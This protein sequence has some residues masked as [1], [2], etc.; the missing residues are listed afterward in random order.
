MTTETLREAVQS[1]CN[2]DPRLGVLVDRWGYPPLWDR[3]EG[4]MTLLFII[5]E[6]QVSLASARATY[7]RLEE[8]IPAPT[9]AGFL[10]LTDETLRTAGFS[11][12]KTGCGRLLAQAIADG[13]LNTVS[14]STLDD[15]EAK[16]RLMAIKGIGSWTADIYVME[17][18]C[19]R[20]IWP[21]G[22][23]ALATAVGEGLGLPNR[24]TPEE[25]RVIGVRWK[26]FRSA[27]ARIFWNAYLKKRG[28]E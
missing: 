17:A 7:R 25:L 8:V 9:P 19:R 3:P 4:F 15:R 14:L 5:L 1:L 24:P 18:L 13:R 27:A 6:Q 21:V 22:D 23:L 28:R 10:A 12:Q 2:A 11:R 26:P 20:D 16:E